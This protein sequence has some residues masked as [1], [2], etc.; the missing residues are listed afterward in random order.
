MRKIPSLLLCILIILL[1]NPIIVWGATPTPTASPTSTPT[2]TPTASPSPT[3]TPTPTSTVK[4]AATKNPIAT[5]RSTTYT[6][7]ENDEE[8]LGLRENL[9]PSPSP[10]AEGEAR[11][12][13]PFVAGLFLFLGIGLIGFAYYSFYAKKKGGIKIN[14]KRKVKKKEDGFNKIEFK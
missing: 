2:A 10:E 6:D 7:T 8:I 5:P 11:G 3:P 9:V 14:F 12:K 13:V 4:A 1:V